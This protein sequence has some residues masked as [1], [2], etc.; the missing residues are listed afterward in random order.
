ML[1]N[2]QPLPNAFELFGVDFLVCHEAPTKP[3]GPRFSLKLLEINAEPAIEMTGPRLRWILEDLFTAA[4]E[5]CVAPFFTAFAE[6]LERLRMCLDI[7]LHKE[8]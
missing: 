6:R 8:C 3:E 2:F 1:P 4:C 5:A 7:R